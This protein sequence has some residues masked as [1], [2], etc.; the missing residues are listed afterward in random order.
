MKSKRTKALDISQ[1]VKLAV[2]ERDEGCCVVCGNNYNTMPNA[3]ILA[4][5]KSGKGI[6][7]N[8]VT[9]CTNLTT[10]KCHYKYDFGTKEEQE[11]IDK[12]IIKYM[13]SIY[14]NDWSKENQTYKKEY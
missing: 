6:E 14:G 3:H 12:I 2:W 5:S 10:N 13:K 7:T 8:I 9:L 1:K 4:R 11:E